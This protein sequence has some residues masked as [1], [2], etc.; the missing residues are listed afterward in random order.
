MAI[1]K[2]N[3]DEIESTSA[4]KDLRMSHAIPSLDAHSEMSPDDMKFLVDCFLSSISGTINVRQ[5][6]LSK[7]LHRME[8]DVSRRQ[9]SNI[10]QVDIAAVAAKRGQAFKTVSNRLSKVRKMYGIHITSS[11][12]APKMPKANDQKDHCRVAK[13]P[14]KPRITHTTLNKFETHMSET[15]DSSKE[16]LEADSSGGYGPDDCKSDE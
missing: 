10:A 13:S 16:D 14:R 6:L 7:L 1:S 2:H 5:L 15:D 12:G 9:P 3:S 11:S 4:K 8:N